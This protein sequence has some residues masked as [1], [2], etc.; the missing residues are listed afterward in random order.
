MA[1][2][3]EQREFHGFNNRLTP[4]MG[5]ILVAAL[6]SIE[7][8]HAFMVLTRIKRQEEILHIVSY[9]KKTFTFL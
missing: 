9:S 3:C 7:G 6:S 4:I 2:H 1:V 5:I 8:V